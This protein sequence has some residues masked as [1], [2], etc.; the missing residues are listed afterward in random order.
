M[1]GG[2]GGRYGA[3]GL[4]IAAGVL[5]ALAGCA[6][7]G[8]PGREAGPSAI[9]AA[10]GGGAIVADDDRFSRPA[11]D[12]AREAASRARL[13]GRGGDALLSAALAVDRWPVDPRNWEELSAAYAVAGRAEGADYARFFA[14]RLPALNAL[15]PRSAA[16]GMRRLEAPSAVTDPE[17]RRAYADAGRLLVRFYDGRY[18]TARADRAAAEAEGR[19]A[20][21]PYLAYPAAI[22]GGAAILSTFVRFARGSG[23]AN[24]TN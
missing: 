7:T 4:A 22:A 23:A 14:R 15:H 6:G 8:A 19:P 24:T 5:L 3:S 18:E 2:R 16:S 21:E 1:A 20:W 10:T 9:G 13:A 11:G 17:L 12:E